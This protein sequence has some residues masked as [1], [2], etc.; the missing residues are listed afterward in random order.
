MTKI[1]RE[2]QGGGEKDEDEARRTE[3]RGEGQR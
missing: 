2:G 3:R 1:R